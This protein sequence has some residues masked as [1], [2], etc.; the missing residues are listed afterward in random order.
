[1]LP[2]TLG[3]VNYIIGNMGY[4]NSENCF[5]NPGESS[6]SQ[7]HTEMSSELD[8]GSNSEHELVEI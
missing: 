2:E 8:S 7:C 6:G 1:M 4:C 5:G 3:I